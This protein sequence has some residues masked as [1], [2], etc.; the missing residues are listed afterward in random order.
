MTQRQTMSV[1]MKA[2]AAFV[3]SLC[4]ALFGLGVLT[5]ARG[6][7]SFGALALTLGIGGVGADLL[8]AAFT[9]NKPTAIEFLS[10]F[11][12]TL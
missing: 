3:G 9:G 7:F 2:A 10:W 6:G 11:W 5:L 8:V 1:G 12:P 4:L